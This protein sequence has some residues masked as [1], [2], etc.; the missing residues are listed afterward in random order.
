MLETNQKRLIDEAVME[1][2]RGNP[3]VTGATEIYSY[4]LKDKLFLYAHNHVGSVIDEK[5]LRDL[6]RDRGLFIAHYSQGQP[7]FNLNIV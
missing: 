3:L 7:S 2:K 5:S 1:I 6:L 4:S